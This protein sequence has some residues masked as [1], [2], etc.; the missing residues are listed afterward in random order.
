MLLLRTA[1]DLTKIKRGVAFLTGML[2][3]STASSAFC[4]TL[5]RPA[6]PVILTGADVPS[7]TGAAPGNIVAF[8]YTGAWEQIP[9]QVD[10]RAVVNY[11]TVYK[12]SATWGGN[13]TRV[14]YTDSRTFTG[15]D[16]DPT[17][18]ADDEIVFM[19]KD[20][21]SKMSSLI[22]PACVVPHSG[23]EIHVTDPLDSGEGYVYLFRQDG[24]LDPG[25][26][27]QY[28]E[29][30]FNLLSGNYKT[31]YRVSDGPN[32]EDTTITTACYARHFA[33]RWISDEIRIYAGGATGADILDRHKNLFAPGVCSRSEDTFS[34]GEGAFICNITGPVRAIRSYVGCN[35]GPLTQRDNI[36]YEQREDITTYL[37]VHAISGVMDFYDYSPAAT[38][39][40]Y[41][42]NDTTGGVTIDGVPDTVTGGPIEWELVTGVQGSLVMTRDVHT[43]IATIHPTSYYLDDD[44]PAVTQCTGDA[45]AFGSSGT[46]IP[47]SIPNTDP[48]LGAAYYLR[49]VHHTYY[50]APGAVVSDTEEALDL[51]NN[52]LECTAGVWWDTDGD[53]VIDSDDAFPNNPAEWADAGGD[54]L[55]DNFEMRII[56]F[57]EF[58]AYRTLDDVLPGDDFDGDGVSNDRE[59]QYG[60]DPT[61]PESQVLVSTAA[62]T[63]VLVAAAFALIIKLSPRRA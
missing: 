10:E 22:E 1:V 53:G 59:F 55:G 4:S 41:Y 61:D 28:V 62:G 40:T 31:T 47:Q 57:D 29:Y 11:N 48:A 3:V 15:G 12:G 27:T 24:T 17:L 20:G 32:P 60:T 37:R 7:L 43:D 19:A 21:G 34:D 5:N 26:G 2:V 50:D 56:N 42:N 13:F 63:A 58:D 30:A 23:V 44:T 36:F 39:M 45:F 14:S 54:G 16:P 49:V 35:S 9:V 33:D 6:D 51:V 8:R 25:A 52:P 46:R 18:D 38:G